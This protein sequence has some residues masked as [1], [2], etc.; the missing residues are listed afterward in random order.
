MTL[1]QTVAALALAR[2]YCHICMYM[3]CKHIYQILYLDVM[4]CKYEHYK[5]DA[6]N[7]ET[8]RYSTI[9]SLAT[10]MNSLFKSVFII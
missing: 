3:M 1:K 7:C 10:N 6:L 8:Q 9:C 4:V 5:L 2:I